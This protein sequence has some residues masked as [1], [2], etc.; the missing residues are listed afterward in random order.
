MLVYACS[1]RG[2]TGYSFL[3]SLNPS[4]FKTPWER[5]A[6]KLQHKDYKSE[7]LLRGVFFGCVLLYSL[8]YKLIK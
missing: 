5:P 3:S 7:P 2:D 6:N 1:L 4:G 8:T